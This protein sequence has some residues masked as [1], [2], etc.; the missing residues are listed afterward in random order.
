VQT[1]YSV[2]W[3]NWGK[4]RSTEQFVREELHMLGLVEELGFDMALMPEHHFDVTYSACPDNFLALAWLAARTTTLKLGLGAVILPWNDPLRVVERVSMLDHL[5]EGRV[6]LG[7]GRGLAL[8]EYEAFG[9]DMSESRERFDEAARVVL[10][11]LETGIVEND[12]PFYP[13]PRVEVHPAPTRSFQGR[14]YSVGMSPGSMVVAGELGAG[15]AT[16][17][18]STIQDMLPHLQAYRDAYLSSRP[19]ELMDPLSLQ[20][21]CYCHEDPDEA[22]RVARKYASRYYQSVVE[23]YDFS[24]KHFGK[25]KGYE[26]YQVGADAIREAGVDAATEA[27]LAAQ[28]S[29]GTPDQILQNYQDRVD[30]VGEIIAGNGFFYGGMPLET[31]EASMRL[32]AREVLPELKKMKPRGELAWTP[33][34]EGVP[35]AS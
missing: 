35:A 23:H 4:E 32:F 16:F 3:Q 11:G 29:I 8:M 34:P 22:Q 9:Y 13:Q 6:V 30:L 25:I 14:F 20:D 17:T 28:A 18:T 15:L 5:S 33:I 26:Q 7:F 12:G 1:S 31:A 10:N 2:L 24:G 27:Y 19:G 21:F